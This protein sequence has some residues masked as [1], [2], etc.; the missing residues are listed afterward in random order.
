MAGAA[1]EFFA[2]TFGA[3]FP[4]YRSRVLGGSDLLSKTKAAL[5]EAIEI[6]EELPRSHW[7]WQPGYAVQTVNSNR[8][9]DFCAFRLREDPSDELALW[10]R[11]G[12]ALEGGR[13][14]FGQ[15]AFARLK[16]REDFDVRWPV[17]AGCVVQW[18]WMNSEP[19]RLGTFLRE[20][21]LLSAAEP[22]LLAIREQRDP[23]I[24][25][26]EVEEFSRE[27]AAECIDIAL[28]E[29]ST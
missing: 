20:A 7:V 18:P 17:Y 12:L 1:E 16:N 6:V 4:G 14:D 26:F 27:C 29:P 8:L 3:G 2:R 19:V 11:I 9:G 28:W 15:D 22:T 13:P 5:L 10:T 23:Y 21:G 24:D 25:V